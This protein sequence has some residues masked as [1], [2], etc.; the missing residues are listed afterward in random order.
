MSAALERSNARLA[1]VQARTKAIEA[2]AQGAIGAVI[3]GVV[4]AR[5]PPSIASIA[6]GHGD[7]LAGLVLNA[8][9][10]YTGTGP[11]P[12]GIGDV[13]DGILAVAAFK[14]AAR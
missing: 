1:R 2:K 3:G 12:P 10:V 11:L 6:S 14:M 5:M 4:A 7:L 9:S 8:V 13:G